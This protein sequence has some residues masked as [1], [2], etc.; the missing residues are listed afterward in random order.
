MTKLA[1]AIT[2]AFLLGITLGGCADKT[3]TDAMKRLQVVKV[4]DIARPEPF[5]DNG[6]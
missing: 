1:F 5:Q 3:L 6:E 2:V 4:T